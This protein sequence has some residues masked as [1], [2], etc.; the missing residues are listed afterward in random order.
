MVETTKDNKE[1]ILDIISEAFKHVKNAYDLSNEPNSSKDSRLIFPKKRDESIR[2]SEQNIRV[3]EQEL[4]FAFVEEF[5]KYVKK[6]KKDWYYAVE[7]PTKIKY[8]FS[9]KKNPKVAEEGKGKSASFDLAIYAKGD[10]NFNLIA[11]LEF[12]AGNPKKFD[13][14][15]DLV[16]L[17]NEKEGDNEVLRFFIEIVKNA[18]E[19]TP[20][21]IESKLKDKRQQTNFICY[22]LTE[23]E[24]VLELTQSE[25]K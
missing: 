16:K 13:Y 2:V 8:D 1:I 12:K 23:G 10:N 15:K 11:L 5:L 21:N 25:N 14:H 17:E 6:K 19:R 4:R 7:V 9:D 22:S 24:K 20:K 3:S 18:D